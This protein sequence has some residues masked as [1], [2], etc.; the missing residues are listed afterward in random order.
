M[1]SMSRTKA[2]QVLTELI[3]EVFRLNGRLLSAG[4][5]LTRPVGQTSARWQILG[6]LDEG[7]RTVADI[8]RRMGLTRQSVQRTADLLESDGL[9][10]YADNP[11]HQRAKLAKLTPRGLTTLDAITSRQIEW[12]N[13]VASRLAEADL[14]HAIRT[15]QQVRESLE[16]SAV[17]SELATGRLRLR[18]TSRRTTPKATRRRAS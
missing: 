6:A 12:A 10:S 9:L 18:G 11:A 15:L 13:L 2:S 1:L 14:H 17:S 8:G 3:L 5:A 4:D 7:S 16:H